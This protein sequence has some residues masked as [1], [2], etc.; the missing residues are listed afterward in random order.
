M[1][2][3]DTH[4]H[5]VEL[6]DNTTHLRVTCKGQTWLSAVARVRARHEAACAAR[7]AA[8]CRRCRRAAETAVGGADVHTS[9]CASAHLEDGRTGVWG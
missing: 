7:R 3:A 9:S 5:E 1:E 8:V 6:V 2:K 4:L